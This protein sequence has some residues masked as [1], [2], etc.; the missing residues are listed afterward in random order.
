MQLAREQNGR[1]VEQSGSWAFKVDRAVKAP[2]K[3]LPFALKRRLA[4]KAKHH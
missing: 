4:S 3:T 2:V 1:S